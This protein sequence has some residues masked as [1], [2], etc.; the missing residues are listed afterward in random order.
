MTERNHP[1]WADS[2]QFIA[3]TIHR[4]DIL[5]A[6]ED[7]A[8]D[9]RKLNEQLSIPKA[10]LRYNLR[11]LVDEGYIRS[12]GSK[13]AITTTGLS[14]LSAVRSF[15]EH[16][17]CLPQLGD[18]VFSLQDELSLSNLL[19]LSR[20]KITRTTPTTP[21]APL[22]ELQSEL[23]KCDCFDAIVPTV[24][25]VLTV[26]NG[27][28]E[29]VRF[30]RVVSNEDAVEAFTDGDY[31]PKCDDAN[32]FARKVLSDFGLYVVDSERIL[33]VQ[34]DELNRIEML[35]TSRADGIRDWAERKIAANGLPPAES[36]SSGERSAN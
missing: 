9:L 16:I 3:S 17:E 13:F 32:L 6:L 36:C 21:Y 24:D 8:V 2:F 28:N 27:V 12:S 15:R 1:E 23:S 14:A 5:A 33:L 31:L 20:G 7:E 18:F 19:E 29:P 30:A 35:V 22:H 11:E 10:T 25:H 26:L 4:V 34:Y